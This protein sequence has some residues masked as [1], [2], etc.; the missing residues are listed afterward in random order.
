MRRTYLDTPRGQIHVRLAGDG[1][2]LIL[3]LHQTA[4]SSVMY[5]R[6]AAEMLAAGCGA[7]YR[8]LAPDTPGFGMSFTPDRPYDLNDWAADMFAAL[9]SVD[10]GRVHLLGHHTGAA[11]AG[12][13]AATRPTG[14][15]AW[16]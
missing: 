3:L 5:E 11:I 12:V 16:R 1:D 6:F 4:A 14:W 10:A 8:L 15:R 7:R 13:M 2:D 9:D